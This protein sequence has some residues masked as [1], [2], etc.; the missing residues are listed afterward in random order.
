MPEHTTENGGAVRAHRDIYHVDDGENH[1]FGAV[2]AED[3]LGMWFEMMGEWGCRE[4]ALEGGAAVRQLTV[5]EAEAVTIALDEYEPCP[6]PG[7]HG[8][9]VQKKVTLREMHAMQPEGG[10]LGTSCF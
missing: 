1:W 2:S 7:C 4:E 6:H 8:G 3:A 9:Q 5:A 10:L